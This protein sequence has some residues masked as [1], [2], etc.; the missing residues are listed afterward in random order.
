MLLIDRLCYTSG[1]RHMNAGEKCALSLFSIVLCVGTRSAAAAAALVL[2]MA[3]LCIKKGGVPAGLYLRLLLIP[4]AFVLLGTAAVLVNL[5]RTPLNAFALPLGPLW[6]TGSRE[7]LLGGGRLILTAMAS[8]SGLYFLALTTPVTD[9]LGVLRA[10]RLPRI[11]A[12]LMLLVYRFLFLLLEQ[13][14]AMLRS[15]D[16]RLGNR[17]LRTSL[18]S[19]G[20]LASMLFIRAMKQGNA[21]YDAMEARCYDGSIRVLP[22]ADPPRLREIAGIAGFLF[23]LLVLAFLTR[24]S[25]L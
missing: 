5:S 21:L 15:Q 25:G 18:R 12:E 22:E 6:L 3:F 17:D 9:I 8:V 16:A 2:A 4:L 11:L 14:A 1:L 19:R 10:C 23:L 20:L 13:A 24:K 7:G